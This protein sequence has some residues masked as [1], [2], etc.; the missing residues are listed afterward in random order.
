[1]LKQQYTYYPV[2]GGFE[3]VNGEAD[4]VRPLYSPHLHDKLEGIR[5]IYYLGDRPKLVLSNASAGN[6]NESLMRHGHLFL[7]IQGGKWL[8]EMD[9]IISRYVYG[10]EE[11]E[12]TDTSFQGKIR[13]S[14]LPAQNSL[15][16]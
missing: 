6:T 4:Y 1:M 8:H 16:P 13:R 14:P 2:P 3:T 11:Y 9:R 15:M 7:G 5:Y 12:V 10:H